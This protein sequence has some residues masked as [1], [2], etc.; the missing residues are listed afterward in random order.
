MDKYAE[1]RAETTRRFADATWIHQD[2]EMVSRAYFFEAGVFETGEDRRTTRIVAEHFYPEGSDE[3]A[4]WRAF[5]R[6]RV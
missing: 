6:A 2:A 1:Y 4:C 5:A 3:A